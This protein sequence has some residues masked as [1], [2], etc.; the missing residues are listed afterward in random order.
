MTR[1]FSCSKFA[2]LVR[3]TAK[4][5]AEDCKGWRDWETK[6]KT[7][8]PFR[9]WIAETALDAIQNIIDWIP[10]NINNVRYYLNNR[11]ITRPN[12][13]TAHPRDI[14]PGDWCDLSHR[15]LPCM[16]NALVDFIECEKGSMQVMHNNDDNKFDR[17][18]WHKKWWLRWFMQ[19]R[20]A[21]AGLAYLDWEMKLVRDEEYGLSS[22]DALY[23]TPTEQAK[24]AEI[25]KILYLWWT[26]E[27]P[28]RLDP[29][30][31]SEWTT[32]C[33]LRREKYGTMFWEDSTDEE[34]ELLKR[35]LAQIHELETMYDN[36]D[37]QM[38]INLI[39]IRNSLWT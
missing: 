10:N 32:L 5:Y 8:H 9:Y 6:A 21:E 37:T 16:F 7:A 18:F 12:A 11:F 23:N 34:K 28:K 29:Y 30:D 35:S 3:G 4:P 15:L 36:E 20:N 22:T 38:M 25:M 17:P 2:D 31:V 1:Y 19:Y 27:R 33:E 13:L 24:N 39:N 26:E 14:K